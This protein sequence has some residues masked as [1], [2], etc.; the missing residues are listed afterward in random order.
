ML[1]I[2]QSA[3]PHAFA[4]A[5]FPEPAAPQPL[6][7]AEE[8]PADSPPP[9]TPTPPRKADL[10]AQLADKENLKSLG[11]TLNQ[12]AT[13]LGND[14]SPQAVLAALASTPMDIH[15]ASSYAEQAGASVTLETFIETFLEL[16]LPSSHFHLS[17][18]AR[19]VIN[20]SMEHPL[21]DLGGA[22]SWPVPLNAD[23]Q[24]R[25]RAITLN[26]EHALGD[27][28]LVMQ[29]KG[30]VLEFLRY[31]QPLGAQP[32][33]APAKTLEALIS[34]PQAQLMGQDL[35]QRMQ[36]IANDSSVTDYLLAGIA[37]QLDPESI[38][39][40][41]RNQIAG[42]DL[43]SDKHWGKPLSAVVDGLAQW[44][45]DKG[46]TSP[47]MAKVGAH[48]LLASRAPAF[49]IK[50]IP[51]SV[52]YG[53]P[54]WVNLAVA[55]ATI[56]ARTPGKLPNMTFAQVM[57]EAES[58][59]LADT[60][61]TE[62]AQ[63]EALIDWG[64]VHGVLG[65]KDDHLYT[66]D[67]LKT[68]VTTFNARKAEMA[69][70]AE[71]LEKDIPSRKEMARA[72]C[73]E[74]FPELEALFEEKLIHVSRAERNVHGHITGYRTVEVGPHSLLD[75]A[76]MDLPGPDLV[77]TSKDKRIPVEQ[78][79]ANPRFGVPE[80]FESEFKSVIEEKKQ[81]TE[82]YIK[83]MISQ[84]TG[85]HLK[86]FEFGKITFYQE[87]S[88]TL[89]L[90]LYGT[91]AN[92][93]GEELL[94]KIER[95]GVETEYR[96]NF[97]EGRIDEVPTG[98]AK[99]R[100]YRVANRVYE[101]KEFKP[102]GAEALKEQAQT[103]PDGSPTDA[104][105][106]PRVG[107]IAKAF[108]EHINLD[109]NAIKQQARGQTTADNNQDRAEVVQEFLLDLVPFRSAIQN[110]RAGNIG[111]GIFDLGLDLFGFVTAGAATAGKIAKIAGT[112]ASRVAKGLK[113]ARA[114]GMATFS[115]LNPLGGLG[116]LAVGGARQAGKGIQF[117]ANNGA[118]AINTVRGA[119]GSY[120]VLKAVS[121]EH[122]T[123]LLGTYKSGNSSFDTVAV[124]K[125]D[126]WYHYNPANN[127]VYGSPI[128]H[129]TP[130]GAPLLVRPGQGT[131]DAAF[132]AILDRAQA[133]VADYQRGLTQGAVHSIPGY[134]PHLD[135]EN[136]KQIALQRHLTPEQMGTLT[137]EIKDR[138]IF[139]AQY[140]SKVLYNDVHAPGVRVTPVSQVDYLAHVDLTSRGEC[141]A[142]SNLM[143]LAIMTGKEDLLMQNLYRAARNPTD[144]IAAEFID[145][146][147]NFQRVVGQRSSFH[148]GKPFKQESYQNIID[149]L[150]NSTTSKT[151]RIATKDHGMIAGIK[152]EAGKTEWFFYE[153]NS[154]MVKFTTLKSMQEGMEKALNSGGIAQTLNSYSVN[155]VRH[156]EVSEFSAGDMSTVNSVYKGLLDA[157]L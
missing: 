63:R 141:A 47:E 109:N 26:H 67:D 23:E 51:A 20:R 100:S 77:F 62:T 97:N 37:L 50:D 33:D 29:T 153:P 92:P 107:L 46:K 118:K 56:E 122:G 121:K 53:S 124:L 90:E 80:A 5:L 48:L 148:M 111:E 70:A 68:L 116:D 35:Q 108:V 72:V 14:A 102:A 104:F 85:E 10:A 31:Q 132:R 82:T 12:L 61:V 143:A 81:G 117:L 8:S 120:D 19:A 157:T 133:S 73:K 129:F 101:I 71:A 41:H 146:L 54:A 28:P 34:T 131:H 64:V 152:V 13:K 93:I 43:A 49:L 11:Q 66:A 139:E 24:Q 130:I 150:T 15:S 60:L 128:K 42:F 119:T 39:A 140:I 112:A 16:P 27:K 103:P 21:G 78:L 79:I 22:L 75:I 84:L 126:Q 1:N 149:D 17:G 91:T 89:G 151:L 55:A 2:T 58:A 145:E 98:T 57:L 105:A 52:T 74:R 88:K 155:R 30:G 18:L 156:Y 138:K 65:K 38:T 87:H 110:F 45:S 25:L 154:G 69:V 142:L 114:I 76:M 4:V 6:L 9:T 95:D 86:N 144:S 94:V 3:S 115:T 44:L 59:S 7:R 113:A 134:S 123:A 136:L 127:K 40:P 147:E 135:A 32:Q 106:S 99:L 96:I 137:R 36:G 83:H 125:N